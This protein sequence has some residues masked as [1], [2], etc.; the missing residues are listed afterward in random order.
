VDEH[1]SNRLLKTKLMSWNLLKG[2]RGASAV[3]IAGSMLLIMGFAAIAIDYGAAVNERRL[4]QSTADTAVLSAGVEIIVSGDVQLAVDSA[5]AF[6]NQNLNRIVSDAE[7]SACADPDALEFPS[8]TIPGVTNGSNCISFGENDSGIAY[9]KIRVRLPDQTSPP[10]FSR[11]LGSAGIVT[12]AS[13]EVQLDTLFASGAFPSGVFSGAS[14]GEQFCIK[15]GTAGQESCGASTTGDFGNF[16]PYF[17]TELAPGSP[18]SECTS[19]NQPGPLSRVIADGLDHFLGI[20]STSTGSRV[21]GGSCPAFPG[22]LLPDRV[23]SG[24]GNSNADL[25]DGLIQGGN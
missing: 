1:R 18:S 11:L 17:Y 7:W 6:T 15:T 12:S 19:G 14:A 23:D 2:E 4:D 21:N 13:A 22:P 20:S 25:T 16:Q 3:L 9:A 10:I 24:G 8:N 5:K